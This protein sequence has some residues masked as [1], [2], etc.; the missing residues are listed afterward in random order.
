MIFKNKYLVIISKKISENDLKNNL[1]N[2]IMMEIFKIN[3]C[4][5]IYIY[6]YICIYISKRNRVGDT[7]TNYNLNKLLLTTPEI[8]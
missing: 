4:V 8:N 6:I 7:V 2:N 1:Y 5:L 3:K